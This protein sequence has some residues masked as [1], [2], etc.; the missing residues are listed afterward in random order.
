VDGR[1]A[2]GFLQTWTK[3]IQANGSWDV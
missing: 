3:A 2:F 1:N